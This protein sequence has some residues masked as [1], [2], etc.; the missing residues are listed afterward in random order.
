MEGPN[1]EKKTLKPKEFC[2][3]L[4]NIILNFLTSSQNNCFF[5]VYFLGFYS[6]YICLWLIFFLVFFLFKRP[7]AIEHMKHF[8]FLNHLLFTAYYITIDLGSDLRDNTIQ[9]Y[10]KLCSLLPFPAIGCEGSQA[11]ASTTAKHSYGTGNKWEPC[12]QKI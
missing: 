2:T 6:G 5:T 10:D 12:K 7:E 3:V 8:C 1:S 9:N 4:A 11:S